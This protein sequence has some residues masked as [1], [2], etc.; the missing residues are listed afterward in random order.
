V[1]KSKAGAGGKLFG[2]VTASAIADAIE[3]EYGYKPDKKKIT[4][5]SDI[6]TFGEYPAEVKFFQGISVKITV[7]VAPAAD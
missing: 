1:I 5:A 4:I 6:K 7:A 3:A 2:A